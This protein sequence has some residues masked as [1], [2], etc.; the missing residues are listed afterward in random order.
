MPCRYQPPA[1]ISIQVQAFLRCNPETNE[2][3]FEQK[4]VRCLQGTEEQ[5][6]LIFRE[7]AETAAQEC[8]RKSEPVHLVIPE[9]WQVRAGQRPQ[10]VIVYAERASTGKLGKSRWSLT[11]PH[12]KFGPKHKPRF[13]SYNRG[14]IEGILTLSDNS[15]IFVNAATTSEAKR[16]LKSLQQFVPERLLQNAHTKVGERRGAPYRKC[17]VVPTLAKYFSKGQ[18]QLGPDWTIEFK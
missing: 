17:R 11:I 10:L 8:K 4:L 16:V 5:T 14:D 1:F 13:P 7:I 6:R 9:W 15:K 18:G 12:Y 2:P 3:E